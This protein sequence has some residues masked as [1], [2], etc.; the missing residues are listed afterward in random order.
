MKVKNKSQ[1]RAYH[2]GAVLIAPGATG[3]VLDSAE[4]DLKGEKDLEIVG[5]P[6]IDEAP[7]KK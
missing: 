5:G 6:A 4:A 2:V 1:T 7:K 3:E